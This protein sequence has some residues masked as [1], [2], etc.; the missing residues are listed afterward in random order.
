L[1]ILKVE[2]SNGYL[3]YWARGNASPIQP[4]VE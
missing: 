4:E 3:E 2:T 1:K